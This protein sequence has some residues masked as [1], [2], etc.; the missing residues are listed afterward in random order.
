MVKGKAGEVREGKKAGASLA[1]IGSESAGLPAGMAVR[2]DDPSRRVN[3]QFA[4]G[5][6]AG[7]RKPKA[8][9]RAYLEAVKKAIPPEEVEQL[10]ADAL[11]M[12]RKTNS[13]RGIVEVLRIAMDYGAGKPTQ[14]TVTADG[15]LETLLAAL[16]DDTPLLPG[17]AAHSDPAAKLPEPAGTETG[18]ENGE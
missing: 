17:G 8:V 11:E 7:G 16:A 9:E 6:S 14:K 1:I 13:W 10:L 5:N 3:G 12:A 15:N 4:A 18:G 2:A